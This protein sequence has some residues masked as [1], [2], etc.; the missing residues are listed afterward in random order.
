MLA[1]A[2]LS[3][4]LAGGLYAALAVWRASIGGFGK[5]SL[6]LGL[7]FAGMAGWS[8]A[9]LTLAGIAPVVAEQIRN[10]LWIVYL[11]FIIRRDDASIRQGWVASLPYVLVALSVARVLFVAPS[12]ATGSMAGNWPLL[13]ALGCSL[14][15]C[16]GALIFL[17][18]LH[19]AAHR[20]ASG[21]KLILFALAVLWACDLNLY[22]SVLLRFRLPLV[23][24]EGRGV[25]ALLLAPLFGIAARRKQR[26]SIVLSRKVAFQSLSVVAIGGYFVFVSTIASAQPWLEEGLGAAAQMVAIILVSAA[27]IAFLISSRVRGTVRVFVSKHLFEHRYDYR[28][29][30]LRFNATI[31]S[32]GLTGLSP[33]QRA[34]KSLA[35]LMDAAGG[36]LFLRNG[37]DRL[38]CDATFDWPGHSPADG[39]FT[40]PAELIELVEKSSHVM[41]SPHH[42][43]ERHPVEFPPALAADDRIWRAV[44]RVRMSGL[45]GIIVLGR[46]SVRRRL[47]WEDFDLLK[48]LS[49]QIATYIA[50]ARSQAELE[51]A[52]QFEEFNRRFAFI[53]HDVKNVVSQL[54]LIVA[55]AEEHGANPRFQAD[56]ASTLRNSVGK[57]TNL[58]SRLSLDRHSEEPTLEEVDALRLLGEIADARRSQHP[59][60][61]AESDRLAVVADRAKLHTAIDHLVQNAI[62]ASDAM[63][64]VILSAAKRQGRG[65]LSV[66]DTGG[67]MT[68]DFVRRQLFKPFASTKRA[69]F[70]IG[71]GEARLLIRQMGGELD[72][73]SV[74][75]VGTSF[76]IRLPVAGQDE[77]GVVE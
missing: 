77:R 33:E 22:A 52:R 19:F 48:V 34:I 9:D 21:F 32:G 17:H 55:N 6:L 72:V 28:A 39:E 18:S 41:I 23:L 45:V 14:G 76:I 24:V 29:E 58:L 15:F 16:I 68:A 61:I 51:E 56:M 47:D 11:S 54:S 60:A 66:F 64:P 7:S 3:F 49:Q 69:G 37:H 44:P 63:Q 30:W 74:E 57:M 73:Q 35:D 20:E 8:L 2:S 46:S 10:I 31:N 71:A 25:V 42:G 5:A 59:V 27:T 70:G 13:I 53:V 43:G 50:E 1:V 12:A 26:W 65:V 38:E 75:G 62:E 36:V 40:L 67:G 4:L